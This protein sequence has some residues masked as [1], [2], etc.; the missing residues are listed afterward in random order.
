MNWFTGIMVY[1]VVWW[2]VFFAALPFGVQAPDRVEPGHADGAPDKP[3]LWMKALVTSVIAGVI[4]AV[5]YW[6]IV[7]DLISF[8]TP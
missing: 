2:L 7:S 1:V 4:F 8:R 5:I 3:R 6:V